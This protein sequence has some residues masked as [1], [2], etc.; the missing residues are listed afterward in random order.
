MGSDE[1]TRILLIGGG[2]H[3]HSVLDSVISL[4]MYD[5]I[6][7]VDN[8]YISPYLGVRVVGSDHDLPKLLR[9]GWR[10]A[11][12]T[13][14]SVGETIIRR[15]IFENLNRIGFRITSII[16]PTATI[17]QGVNIKEGCFLGK[18]SV[19]N[20]GSV[21]G[22]CCIINTG[23]IVEHDCKIGPFAHISSGAVLCGEVKIGSDSH[24]GAGSVVRQLITVSAHTVVGAGSVVVKDIRDGVR[25]YGNP[26]RVVS[27]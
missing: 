7:I 19:V 6:G 22:E 16:D 25:A 2:G 10:N 1:K 13:V 3:C 21:L 20:T 5:E 14:G 15:R 9:D 27:K 4:N 17:A 12:I 18:H 23:A 24:I 11:I 8:D 26:C